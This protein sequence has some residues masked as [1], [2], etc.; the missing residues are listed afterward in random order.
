MGVA[1]SVRGDRF[2][3]VDDVFTTGATLTEAVR[4][5]RDA[6]AEI[7]GA[8]TIANTSIRSFLPAPQN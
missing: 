8:A 7:V 1:K 5:L 4:V 6:G 3:V 2:L